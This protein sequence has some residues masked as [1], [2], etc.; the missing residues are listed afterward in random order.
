MPGARNRPEQI[1][2]FLGEHPERWPSLQGPVRAPAGG[3]HPPEAGSTKS[4]GAWRGAAVG[5]GAIR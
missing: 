1:L 4:L 2:Q 3:S 5:F